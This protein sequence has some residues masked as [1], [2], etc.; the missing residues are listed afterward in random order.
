[1][2]QLLARK[3]EDATS[4]L[5]AGCAETPQ[6]EGIS[7]NPQANPRETAGK[8]GTVIFRKNKRNTVVRVRTDEAPPPRSPP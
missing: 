7:R 8:R 5:C 6:A 3:I 4:L 2:F 1:M